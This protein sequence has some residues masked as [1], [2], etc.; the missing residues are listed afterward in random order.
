MTLSTASY[1]DTRHSQ[2]T[3]GMA[4]VGA[5][6]VRHRGVRSRRQTCYPTLRRSNRYGFASVL[7]AR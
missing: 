1:A 7:A 5:H 3:V 4:F 2:L 6:E